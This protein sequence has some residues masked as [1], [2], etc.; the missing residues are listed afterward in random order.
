MS[1]SSPTS[2]SATAAVQRWRHIWL[3]EGFATYA[4]WLWS[5]HD[6]LATAQELF[7]ENYATPS[8][9]PFWALKIGDPGPRR[10]F[11]GAV[12]ERGAMT[13]HQLRL[14]IGDAAFFELL[15]QWYAIHAG[16]HGRTGAFIALA[17]QVS[18]QELGDLF[19]EWLFTE[20]KPDLTAPLQS[21]SGGARWP[22][23]AAR[24]ERL[25]V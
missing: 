3:N 24:L 18:G 5:E 8:R 17:E 14:V 7:D 16:G 11:D 9:D 20:R 4:E 1:T 15:H 25:R 22:V 21:A 13:L 10:L 23:S 2:G 19:H 12:Y 6:G